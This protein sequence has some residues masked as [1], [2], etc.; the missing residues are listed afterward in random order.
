MFAAGLLHGSTQQDF[1]GT[2][3]GLARRLMLS[4]WQAGDFA[5]E[6]RT[7]WYKLAPLLMH[8]WLKLI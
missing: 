7:A 5:P 2:A 6:N 8:H 1:G 4:Y 3:A